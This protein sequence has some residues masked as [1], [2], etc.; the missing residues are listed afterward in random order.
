M[1]LFDK[2]NNLIMGSKTASTQQAVATKPVTPRDTNP[3]PGKVYNKISALPDAAQVAVMHAGIQLA[4]AISPPNAPQKA[5]KP[6][7]E[8]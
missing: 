5:S 8:I 4:T 6:S 2:L 7:R 1:S 3:T